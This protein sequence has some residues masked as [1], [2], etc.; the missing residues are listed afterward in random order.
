MSTFCIGCGRDMWE[1]TYEAKTDGWCVG[2]ASECYYISG[3]HVA[4]RRTAE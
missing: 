4:A 3:I 2:F 1:Y